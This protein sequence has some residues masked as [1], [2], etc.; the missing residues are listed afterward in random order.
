MPPRPIIAISAASPMRANGCGALGIG[1]SLPLSIASIC[2]LAAPRHVST[3][4]GRG[5]TA[6]ISQSKRKPHQFQLP[7]RKVV[8]TCDA[9]LCPVLPALGLPAAHDAANSPAV[10]FS[11]QAKIAAG[12]F[13]NITGSAA[14]RSPNHTVGGVVARLMCP[15]ALLLELRAA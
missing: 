11:S 3:R 4:H 5:G 10:A 7:R 9:R 12:A 6:S 2:G 15:P 1:R 8:S 13:Q 14:C